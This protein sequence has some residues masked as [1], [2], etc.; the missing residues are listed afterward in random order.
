M[1]AVKTVSEKNCKD[2]A[3]YNKKFSVCDMPACLKVDG[4]CAIYEAGRIEN[5]YYEMKLRSAGIY[6]DSVK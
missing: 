6:G 3:F 5:M 4:F 1:G 2:C